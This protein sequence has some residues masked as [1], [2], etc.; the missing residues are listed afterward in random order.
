MARSPAR[1]ML[2]CAMENSGHGG[3]VAGDR[4]VTEIVRHAGCKGEMIKGVFIALEPVIAKAKNIK[5]EPV[6]TCTT[7]ESIIAITPIK[8]IGTAKASQHGVTVHAKQRFIIAAAGQHIGARRWVNWSS[9]LQMED[10]RRAVEGH[11]APEGQGLDADTPCR[12]GKLIGNVMV[13]AMATTMIR[14]SL[15]T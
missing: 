7:N 15:P 13:S 11:T 4:E 10:H 3:S 5:A 12:G 8:H 2:F 1:T 6:C 14:R 9:R